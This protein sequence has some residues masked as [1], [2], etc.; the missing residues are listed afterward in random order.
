[1]G[2][3]PEQPE[4]EFDIDADWYEVAADSG[5]SSANFSHDAQES[6]RVGYVRANKC[7]AAVR[8]FLGF[9]TADTS[10]PWKLRR[11]QPDWDP[12]FPWLFAH[13]VSPSPIVLLSNPDNANGQPYKLS[14]FSADGKK[15]TL[16]KW[17]LMTV[18]YRAYPGALFL[19]DSVID[20]PGQEYKRN[21][22]TT[23]VPRLEVLSADGGGNVLKYAE[24]GTDGPAIGAAYPAPVP[25]LLPK[26][27]YVMEWM[28]VAREYLTTNPDLMV[29]TKILNC[30][31]KLNNATFLGMPAGTLLCQPPEI[32]ENPW[33]VAADDADE[34]DYSIL[35]SVT[36]R[37]H[38]DFFDPPTGATS[39]VVRG[40][41][42]FPWRGTN[43]FYLAT[44]DGTTS[45]SKA[46]LEY[47]DFA[48]AF[49]H[50][51]AP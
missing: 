9:A 50:V 6:T 48:Q 32:I 29:P 2:A 8:F 33:P 47:V 14:D 13:S 45:L 7:R 17:R 20:T 23:M 22:Q 16:Y 21:T 30:V 27:S 31:G 40:H 19:P 1:M 18:Q 10:S 36:V 11:E 37:F 28:N 12:E 38:F 35:R 25:V 5:G 39:P 34:A 44:R 15:Y 51:S 42:L 3:Y 49:T 43:K 46:F 4:D 24:T 41:N 26:A